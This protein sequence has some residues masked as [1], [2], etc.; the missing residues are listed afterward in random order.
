MPCVSQLQT[1][2]VVEKW[3]KHWQEGRGEACEE[4]YFEKE[5]VQKPQVRNSV[6]KLVTFE[7]HLVCSDSPPPCPSSFTAILTCQVIFPVFF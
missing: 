4:N 5:S 6:N 1:V 3:L 2:H 7:A